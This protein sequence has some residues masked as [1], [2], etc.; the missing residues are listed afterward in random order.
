MGPCILK[1]QRRE[2]LQVYAS[3]RKMLSQILRRLT[4]EDH[5][6]SLAVAVDSRIILPLG[7]PLCQVFVDLQRKSVSAKH[8]G[9]KSHD[10]HMPNQYH[11]GSKRLRLARLQMSTA[12]AVNS[13]QLPAP[14]RRNHL[15]PTNS[16]RTPKET[17][18][19]RSTFRPI[20]P[21]HHTWM[22]ENSNRHSE[23]PRL[24]PGAPE[25][26][27]LFRELAR[28]NWRRL[29]DLRSG[30]WAPQKCSQDYFSQELS[31]FD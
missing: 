30:T 8:I 31:S 1:R 13:A 18:L 6:W 9:S 23:G 27:T 19:G 16:E 10:S 24:F 22:S 2:V 17:W 4:T 25:M 5:N 20:R 21:P 26:L 11:S 3:C 14:D 28:L 15:R 7:L 12:P 29:S